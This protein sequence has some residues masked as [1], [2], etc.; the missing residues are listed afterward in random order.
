MKKHIFTLAMA[1][2]VVLVA[3]TAKADTFSYTFDGTDGVVATGTLTGDA[4]PTGGY[5]I[6]S[7]T[8]FMT[9][10][11]TCYNCG[12]SPISLDGSGVFVPIPG[13]GIFNTGGGTHLDNLGGD[14]SI[15]YPFT[16]QLL[17]DTGIFL[18]QMDSGLGAGLFSYEPQS[19]GYGMFAGNWTI[20]QD[21]GSL[22]ATPEPSS[23]LL[24]GT[25]LL[26]LAGVAR[27]KFVRA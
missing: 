3:S 13:N 11:P 10:A 21:F 7:G 18:F 6:T 12:P 4:L 24:L 5:N 23:L 22:T 20:N 9:G 14:N 25:G 27:R 2:A 26:G 19:T 15:L 16:S 1:I 8:I 17:D